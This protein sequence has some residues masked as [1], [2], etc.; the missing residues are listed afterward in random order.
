MR[1]LTHSIAD[2]ILGLC[3][4]DAPKSMAAVLEKATLNSP[5]KAASA[6]PQ[7]CVL[8][9]SF[10]FLSLFSGIDHVS[11]RLDLETL[12]QFSHLI[13]TFKVLHAHL[14]PELSCNFIH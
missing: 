8:C 13:L 2:P 14:L 11:I 7:M 9:S 3:S 4:Q 1:P 5:R 12:F 6:V 10:H